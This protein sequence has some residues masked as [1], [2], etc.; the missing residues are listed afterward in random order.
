[1]AKLITTL[2]E[3]PFQNWGLD[4]IGPIKLVNRYSN[5]RPLIMLLSGWKLEFCELIQLLLLRS[6]YM[7]IFLPNLILHKLL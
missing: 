7:T 1:M 3:K 4:S 6:S 5:N 2:L